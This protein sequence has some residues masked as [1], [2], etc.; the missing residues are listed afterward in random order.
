MALFPIKTHDQRA[1][2]GVALGFSILAVIA[3]SLRLLAHQLAHKKWTL[4]DYFII[5]ACLFA[6]GLQSI[7]ITGVFQAGIGYGHV[8]EIAVEYGLE[9]ITKLSQL[10]I[11]LQFLWVLSLS[12]TKI[13][14]LCLYLQIFPFR[15]LAWASYATLSLIAAWTVATILAGCLICHPF[16]FNW[17]KKIPGGY[18]G[19]QVTSFTVTG[20]FNLLTDA[21]VLVLP[22]HPLYK[23][24][25]ATYK[26]ATLIAVFGLGMVTCIISALRISVL[27]SMDFADITYTLPKANIFSG[28]EPCI[29]VVLACIPL[30]R[31]LLGRSAET[32]Y[33]SGKTPGNTGSKDSGAKSGGEDGFQRLDDDT[34]NLVLR[35]MG[36]Q[37]R[38]DASALRETIV[39]IHEGSQESLDEGGKAASGGLRVHVKQTFEVTKKPCDGH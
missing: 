31:P 14:I 23:L 10:I 9:P 24:Q 21:I 25:M 19:N 8:T 6:V 28:L 29:A 26:K 16:E 5:M 38:A 17:N 7:S 1:V 12:F 4:S 30:M 33:G 37:H 36:L 18:C 39:D 34:S 15:W 2:L 11:P 13:S 3:V 22:M 27:S 20:I 32:P 35:P